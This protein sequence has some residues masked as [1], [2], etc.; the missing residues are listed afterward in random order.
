MDILEA[1]GHKSVKL[2]VKLSSM[3]LN[4][5]AAWKMSSLAP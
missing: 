2:P 3:L 4:Q 5:C 1:Q